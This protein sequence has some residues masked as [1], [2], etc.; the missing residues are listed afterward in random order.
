MKKSIAQFLSVIFHPMFV[1]VYVLLILL[2]SDAYFAVL[3]NWRFKQFLIIFTIITGVALPLMSAFL[4]KRMGLISSLQMPRR[5]ERIIPFIASATFYFIAFMS[6]NKIE[7]LPGIYALLFL[8]TASLILLTAAITYFWKISIHLITLGSASGI[9]FALLL[10]GQIHLW[11]WFPII[12]LIGGFVGSARL[13]LKAHKPSQ[14]YVGFLMGFF[15]MIL[16][17][18]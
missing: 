9:L 6:L 17:F 11:I 13:I 3:L 4:L 7:H 5:E 15:F 14:I 1:P 16:I 2:Q 10:S 18:S 12:V 8:S